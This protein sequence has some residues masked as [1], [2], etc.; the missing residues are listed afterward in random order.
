MYLREE[1]LLS[2]AYSSH[3]ARPKRETPHPELRVRHR[4]ACRALGVFLLA[5]VLVSAAAAQSE[6]NAAAERMKLNYGQMPLSFERNEGQ[7]DPSVEFLTR[8]PGYGLFLTRSEA[9]LTFASTPP[10]PSPAKAVPPGL[11][12]TGPKP[13]SGIGSEVPAGVLRMSLIGANRDASVSGAS[14]LP[15]KINY[16]IGNDPSKWRTNIPTYAHVRYKNVYPGIDLVYYG[17]Q[18]GQLEYDFIV[19]PGADPNT[20]TLAVQSSEDAAKAPGIAAPRV[21]ADGDLV[22]PSASADLRLHKPLVQQS[23]AAGSR[24]LVAADFTLDAAN[25]V[26]FALGPYDHSQ[27]LIIDPILIFSTYLGGSGSDGASGI[28]ADGAGNVYV[29]GG[30]TSAN[31]PTAGMPFQPALGVAQSGFISKFNWDGSTLSLVYSTYLGGND[32]NNGGGDFCKA[33]AIDSSGDAYV[34]GLT[35]SDN[36]PVLDAIQPTFPAAGEDHASNAFVTELNPTGS[37][38][39]F[40]TYL[41]GTGVNCVPADGDSCANEEGYSIA[42]GPANDVYVAGQ[43]RSSDFPV[44]NAVEPTNLGNGY[45]GFLTRLHFSEASLSFVYSTFIGGSSGFDIAYAVAVDSSGDAYVT[46]Y[47]LSSDFPVANAYQ[48]IYAGTG[49]LTSSNAFVS[50][51]HWNGSTLSFVYSTFFGGSAEDIGEGITVDSA[52]SAYITGQAS[53]SNFPLTNAFQSMKPTGGAPFVA[54]LSW[55]GTTLSLPYSTFLG[56]LG[57]GLSIAVDSEGDA[58]VAGGTTST[59]FPTMNAI[60]STSASQTSTLR[61]GFISEFNPTGSALLFSTYLGGNP[62]NVFPFIGDSVVALAVDSTGNI[63]AAGETTSSNFPTAHPYQSA[64]AGTQNAFV[65]MIGT[66]LVSIAVTPANPTI[67]QGAAQQFTATGTY[68][69]NSQQNLTSTVTWGSSDMTK[70]TIVTGGANAGLATG[71]GVGVTQITATMGAIVSPDDTLTVTPP[72]LVSIAVAPPNPTILLG[73]MQQFSATGTY[74]DNSQQNITSTVTWASATQAT[75]TIGASTGLAAGVAAG[76]SKITAA[77]SGVTSP[78]D[79]LTVDNP[80][81]V[82]SSASPTHAAAGTGFM[83]TVNGSNFVSTS[84]ISFNGTTET[85][86]FVNAGQLTAQIPA[87][88]VP[89]GASVSVS[90]SNPSPGGGTSGNAPFTIDDFSIAGPGSA[91]NI[92]PGQPTPITITLTPTADGFAN[93]IQLAVPGLPKGM[94]GQFAQNPVTPGTSITM[95]ALTL[96]ATPSTNTGFAPGQHIPL[97]PLSGLLLAVSASALLLVR[98]SVRVATLVPAAGL[99]LLLLCGLAASLAG[100]GGGFPLGNPDATPAGPATITVTATSGTVQHTANVMVNVEQ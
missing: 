60:Q 56:S 16:F 94:T 97:A 88:G 77:L 15:G 43:T 55:N 11:F 21:D 81:P 85:T 78:A 65:A 5:L 12:A 99:W 73:A 39:I 6:K 69:D 7:S 20:I 75:A 38:L 86:T 62:A 34:T 63:Y 96:T 61:N 4:L 37:G 49:G 59:S 2:S 48:S 24:K 29:A 87:S 74:S 22:I 19:A 79:T 40:S 89:A 100:C 3:R 82:V 76:T 33:L 27:L 14:E 31:F 53:S 50:K 13:G 58:Y 46:G 18:S 72:T 80:T 68:S 92:T 83:L 30:T 90:V 28:A 35:T 26:R 67:A 36:F 93:P 41:G 44:A 9:V 42:L 25:R 17:N 23:D 98:R 47:T 10:T 51:L 32:S 8:G 45:E 1:R 66:P 64:L 52:G 95:D 84:T 91:T 54:K 70:A 57:E 71:V